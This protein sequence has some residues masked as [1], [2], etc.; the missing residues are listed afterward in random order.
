MSEAEHLVE[1]RRWLRYAHE[2]LEIAE[3]LAKETGLSRRHVCMF[4]Q[5]SAEKALKGVL[6]FAGV[7]FPRHH[8]L[9]ALQLL[10]PSDWQIKKEPLHLATLTVWAVEVGDPGGWPEAN[11]TDAREAMAQARAVMGGVLQDLR[12]HGFDTGQIG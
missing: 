10:I 9:E 11:E 4:A 2:D 1:V 8:D 12:Q 3:R 5:Q 6:I 7:D